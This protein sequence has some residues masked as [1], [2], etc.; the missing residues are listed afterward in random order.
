MNKTIL[1]MLITGM[2]SYSYAVAE[3]KAHWEYSGAHGPEHWGSMSQ[4]FS[5]CAVGKHQSPINITQAIEAELPKISFAYQESPLKVLNNGH[6]YQINYEPGSHVTIDGTDFELKQFHFHTPSENHINGRSFPLEAHLVHADSAGNLAVIGVMFKEGREH[7]LL[8]HL[9][10]RMPSSVGPEQV[11]PEKITV[12]DML[13]GDRDYYR[14]SGSLTTPPCS[15][16]VR[17]LVLKEALEASAAQIGVFK[18]VL[19]HANNRPLQLAN[20]RVVLK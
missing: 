4:E 10:E 13:P 18:S 12:R 2:L 11:L 1:T 3:E 20:A 16:G 7:K 6:T 19:G 9:W 5:V 14:F 17:W 8:R 15:E